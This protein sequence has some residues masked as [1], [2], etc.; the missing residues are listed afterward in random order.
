MYRE[1][2]F[3]SARIR[4]MV[5]NIVKSKTNTNEFIIES[6]WIY[7]RCAREEIREGI[8]KENLVRSTVSSQCTSSLA[9]LP[10]S[11]QTRTSKVEGMK[12]ESAYRSIR[13]AHAS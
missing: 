3:L 13:S 10:S 12:R 6:Q 7:G 1:T 2:S 9:P 8:G 5:K 4:M 11:G